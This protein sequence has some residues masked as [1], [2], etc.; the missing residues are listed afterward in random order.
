[1]SGLG[2]QIGKRVQTRHLPAAHRQHANCTVRNA[3]FPPEAKLLLRGAV[4]RDLY[5]RDQDRRYQRKQKWMS[6]TRWV[7]YRRLL[8]RRCFLWVQRKIT[9]SR[10][11]LLPRSRDLRRPRGLS[12]RVSRSYRPCWLAA[13]RNGLEEPVIPGCGRRG[14]AATCL[15]WNMK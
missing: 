6:C 12:S 13:K 1:M 14:G 8:R 15:M 9:V 4:H 2:L 3:L 5:T 7:R 11:V 10:R